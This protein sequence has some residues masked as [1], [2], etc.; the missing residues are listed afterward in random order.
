MI[1]TYRDLRRLETF[2]ERYEYLR[3][4]GFVGADTFGFDRYLNQEFYKSVLWRRA[5]DYVIARDYGCDLGIEGREIYDRVYVHH[6]NPM[7]PEDIKHSN[8]DIVDPEFLICVTHNTHN[9]IHYGDADRLAK[10]PIER[11][12]GDTKLW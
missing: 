11:R 10:G 12:P 4:G 1:K 8:L 3:L 6:M 5:R 7:T 2:E 9:A